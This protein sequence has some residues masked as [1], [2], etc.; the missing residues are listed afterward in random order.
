MTGAASARADEQRPEGHV[1]GDLGKIPMA[2]SRVDRWPLRPQ[3]SPKFVD[4]LRI[5]GATSLPTPI[6]T[7]LLERQ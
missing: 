1:F 7:L 6:A 3:S 5:Q 4:S 2:H